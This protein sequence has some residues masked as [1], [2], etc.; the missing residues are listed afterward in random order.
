MRICRS[1]MRYPTNLVSLSSL[2]SLRQ[3]SI[4][5]TQ[6]NTITSST[7]QL[8]RR[9]LRIWILRSLLQRLPRLLN[10]TLQVRERP[11]VPR[12]PR[13]RVLPPQ[14]RR[15]ASPPRPPTPHLPALPQRRPLPSP[16]LE[17]PNRPRHR[18]RHRNLGDRIRR[19]V[20]RVPRNRHGSLPHPTRFRAA[21]REILRR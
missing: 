16:H 4:K 20:S 13:R 18:H 1:M 19:R 3:H 2:S 11:S 9:R 8:Q 10:H 21:Q 14:R 7:G 12:L 15:R 17:P 5:F 6:A